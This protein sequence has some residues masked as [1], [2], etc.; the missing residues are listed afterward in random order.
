M[1]LSSLHANQFV[2]LLAQFYGFLSSVDVVKIKEKGSII[3]IHYATKNIS[4]IRRV[5]YNIDEVSFVDRKQ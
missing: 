2:V 1:K 5:I 3:S 4:K